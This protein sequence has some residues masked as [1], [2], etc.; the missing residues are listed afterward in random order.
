[1]VDIVM[2]SCCGNTALKTGLASVGL[3]PLNS[4]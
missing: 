3:Q 4:P 2:A 1:L